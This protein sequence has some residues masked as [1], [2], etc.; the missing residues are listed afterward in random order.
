MKNTTTGRTTTSHIWWHSLWHSWDAFWFAVAHPAPLALVRILTAGVL[1]WIHAV[2][3]TQ[4][5]AVVGETAWLDRKGMQEM[6]LLAEGNHMRDYRDPAGTL[7]PLSGPL[8]DDAGNLKR[9]AAG[10]PVLPTNRWW[11]TF[12]LWHLL[13]ESPGMVMAVQVGLILAAVCVLI[14]VGTRWALLLTWL[15]HVSYVQRGMVIYSGMDAILLL[16]LLYLSVGPAGAVCSIDAWLKSRGKSGPGIV[17][18][19]T[20]ANISLRLIQ[21]HLCLIY[22]CAGAAKL[23]GPTWWNGTA[24][25]LLMMS[26]EYGGVP[27]EWMAQHEMLWQFVSL[28]G[29]IFTVG[30]ELSFAFLVWHPRLRPVVLVAGLFLHVML[31]LLSGLG[32]FQMTMV[33]ALLAFVPAET[34]GRIL[35]QPLPLSRG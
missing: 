15:G 3:W 32:A 8:L 17:V 33:A 25:Y 20:F 6:R 27:V 26:P 21:V 10:N 12:S 9:D 5:S 11:G 28:A 13:P 23:Q 30:F 7:V 34:A 18:P 14:G 1:L 29:G 22:F 16:L 35:R 19:S 24:V 31:A 4:I 2:T